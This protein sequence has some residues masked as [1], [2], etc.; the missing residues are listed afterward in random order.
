[1]YSDAT[2]VC[3]SL[4]GARELERLHGEWLVWTCY[5]TAMI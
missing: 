2:D 4:A 1:M 3:V 5:M